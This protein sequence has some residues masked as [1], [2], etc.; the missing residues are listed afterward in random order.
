MEQI[1]VVT[2]ARASEG[3]QALCQL[4][5]KP[6]SDAYTLI[7]AALVRGDEAGAT[8]LDA[9]DGC[10]ISTQLMEAYATPDQVR[11]IARVDEVEPRA[12]DAALD[13]LDCTIERMD[14]AE[15]EDAARREARHAR[16]VEAI[17]R[18][19]GSLKEVSEAAQ[20]RLDRFADEADDLLTKAGKRLFADLDSVISVLDEDD[21]DEA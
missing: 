8:I 3:Y 15:A 19:L 6:R 1:V 4:R 21:K 12:A 20:T 11:L 2:F 9:T 17:K 16:R 18:G 14:T 10:T 13:G 7:E 5:R